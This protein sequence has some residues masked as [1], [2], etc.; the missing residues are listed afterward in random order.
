MRAKLQEMIKDSEHDDKQLK[1]YKNLYWDTLDELEL[2]KKEHK[3]TIKEKWKLWRDLN[4]IK[5]GETKMVPEKSMI[6]YQEQAARFASKYQTLIDTYDADCN[7]LRR[8]QTFTESM[9]KAE[10]QNK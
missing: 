10:Q 8:G 2:E 9:K 6:H 4:N 3:T 5:K 7:Q 1:K